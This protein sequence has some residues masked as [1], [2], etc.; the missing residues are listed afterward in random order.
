MCSPT[1]KN[2]QP[3]TGS[4]ARRDLTTSIFAEDNHRGISDSLWVQ[5]SGVSVFM[6]SAH[7]RLMLMVSKRGR[8]MASLSSAMGVQL[9]RQVQRQVRFNLVTAVPN[10]LE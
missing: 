2:V 4:S 5:S 6:Q 9:V 3:R 1:V 8:P 7:T 10:I